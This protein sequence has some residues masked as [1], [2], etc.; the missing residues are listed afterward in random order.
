MHRRALLARAVA[1]A[2]LGCSVETAPASTVEIDDW[3]VDLP[4]GWRAT[5]NGI[6]VP[7]F[8]SE[9]KAKGC[10][11]KAIAFAQAHT[12]AKAAAAHIQSIQERIF[13]EQP[14]TKWKVVARSS[15]SHAGVERSELDLYDD[16]AGYRVLSIVLATAHKGLQ[17]TL[18][19]YACASY[20]VSVRLFEPI[21]RSVRGRKP[22][23]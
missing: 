7:Y 11:L 18:H 23:A 21:S 20:A 5:D 16:K 19:D 3:A 2:A 14:G 13:T 17:V 1:F 8:E 10:Y 15:V 4:S 6:G 12:S 9:D 22:G